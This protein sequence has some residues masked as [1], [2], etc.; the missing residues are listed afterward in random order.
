MALT[1]PFS[2]YFQ[3]SLSNKKGSNEQNLR[4][5]EP[6]VPEAEVPAVGTDCHRLKTMVKRITLAGTSQQ[7]VLGSGKEILRRTP[8]SRIRE[9]NS[10]LQRTLRDGWQ[11][12]ANGFCSKEDNCSFRHDINQRAKSTQPNLSPSS[13]TRQNER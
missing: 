12:E 5:R 3:L 6:E 7:L 13:S 8:W 10:V 1:L 9:Q 4:N 11:W 2:L